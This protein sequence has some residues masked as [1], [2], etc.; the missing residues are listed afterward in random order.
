MKF[1]GNHER[2]LAVRV[3]EI[4]KKIYFY[5]KTA[6]TYVI[7]YFHISLYY[8]TSTICA[9]TLSIG[10]FHTKTSKDSAYLT[11]F[12]FFFMGN[13]ENIVR[14]PLLKKNISPEKFQTLKIMTHPEKTQLP[15]QLDNEVPP[16]HPIHSIW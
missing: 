7:H 6:Y 11:R 1:T 10:F 2:P 12:E 14:P 16:I 5:T 13:P 9:H 3:S 4:N 8:V 15:R